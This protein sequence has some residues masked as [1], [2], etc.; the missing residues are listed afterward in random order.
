V[1]ASTWHGLSQHVKGKGE[2][3]D[4]RFGENVHAPVA[5]HR[6]G[7]ER[8]G[9]RNLMASAAKQ[10]LLRAE[11]ASSLTLLAMAEFDRQLLSRGNDVPDTYE[12]RGHRTQIPISREIST[13]R[14]D[15]KTGCLLAD[16]AHGRRK[17]SHLFEQL[18]RLVAGSQ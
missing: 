16:L 2:V 10:S 4:A 18:L 1:K 17:L 6:G 15:G 9:Q 12:D 7:K 3:V 5:H 8:K 13:S 14:K 11:I